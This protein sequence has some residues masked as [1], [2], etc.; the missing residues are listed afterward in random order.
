VHQL[1]QLPRGVSG[2]LLPADKHGQLKLPTDTTFYHLT[3]MVHMS[4]L[5]VGCGQCSS[6]CPN[7]LPVMEL[8]R[9]VAERTQRR[10][11]YQPGA[12]PGEAQPLATFYDEEFGEV[13]GQTK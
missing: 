10:F 12:D 7:D 13:T 5:C 8:F 4:T 3:R 2:V 6:A 11:A 1:L 9:T